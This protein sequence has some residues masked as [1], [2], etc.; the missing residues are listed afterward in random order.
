MADRPD[1]LL[2]SSS[3]IRACG[4]AERNFIKVNII[5]CR[6]AIAAAWRGHRRRAGT[7]GRMRRHARSLMLRRRA[8]TL[9]PAQSAFATV[10]SACRVVGRSGRRARHT[11]R[12][13]DQLLL[14]RRCA[15]STEAAQSA[16]PRDRNS[17]RIASGF[18]AWLGGRAGICTSVLL[19]KSRL[20]VEKAAA[21]SRSAAFA[22]LAVAFTRISPGETVGRGLRPASAVDR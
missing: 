6:A 13:G 12:Y 3:T 8:A 20:L 16:R 15:T 14:N 4:M 9:R 5:R 22:A 19:S 21:H 7:V 2:G 17:T 10:V 11:A 18:T 1:R